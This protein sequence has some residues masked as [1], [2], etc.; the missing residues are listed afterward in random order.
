MLPSLVKLRQGYFATFEELQN[1]DLDQMSHL[2]A[3]SLSRE[4]CDDFIKVL[5]IGKVAE[6][7][8]LNDI[9]DLSPNEFFEFIIVFFS[10]GNLKC[11]NSLRIPSM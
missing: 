7:F 6:L 11:R 10:R 4:I 1:T 5:N 8:F 9:N 3:K 2:S